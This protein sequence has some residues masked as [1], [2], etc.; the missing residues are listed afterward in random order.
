M[1]LRESSPENE[2][3]ALDILLDEGNEIESANQPMDIEDLLKFL[4]EQSE[5]A[6]GADD[7]LLSRQRIRA[8]Q[9]YHGEKYGNEVEGKSQIISREVL[10]AVEWSMPQ[11]MDAFHGGPTVVAYEP[12]GPED[13]ASAEQET[14]WANYVYLR[15]NNG[16]IQS[17]QA[18]KDALLQKD[19][20]IKVWVETEHQQEFEIYE[21]LIEEEAVLLLMDPDIELV[22]KNE[23]TITLVTPEGPQEVPVMD[24][25]V[26]F[27]NPKKKIR[28][29]ACPPD[30]IKVSRRTRFDHQQSPYF[31]HDKPITKSDLSGV[32]AELGSNENIDDVWSSSAGSST[33]HNLERNARYQHD[34]TG[35]ASS[36]V[37]DEEEERILHEEYVLVDANG[38]GIAE[39]LKIIRMGD[40]ILSREEVSYI[41]FAHLTPNILSHK[42]N[43]L[44]LWDLVNDIQLFKTTLQRNIFDNIYLTNNQRVIA[45]A[46]EVNMDDLKVSRAGGVVRENISGAVRPFPTQPLGNQAFDLLGYLDNVKDERTGI[47][48]LSQGLDP[49][50][51]TSN[52]SS[53]AISQV[54]TASQMRMK[55][56]V[57]VLA[58]GFKQVFW[59]IHVMG[60]EHIDADQVFNLTGNFVTV[61]PSTFKDRKD[62]TV[63]VGLGT[64]QQD[65][66]LSK[67]GLIAQDMQMIA[68]QGGMGRIL[69]ESNVYNL[70]IARAK[71]AGMKDVQMYYSDPA[72]LPPP[73]PQPS[74]AELESQKRTEE[75]QI[76]GQKLQAIHAH[77]LQKL[78]I[79]EQSRV[80]I[81]QMKI[82]ADAEIEADKRAM[83]L[84]QLQEKRYETDAEI[85]IETEQGR[86]AEI[87]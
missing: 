27:S 33:T 72:Q 84:L 53:G 13:V 56:I 22:E 86:G 30:E 55:L 85:K 36:L 41:P 79:T 31:A 21:G 34:D 25:K 48:K 50:A 45:L 54:M 15:E 32:M 5:D 9:D 28:V 40:I 44:S 58:E 23:R 14:Q 17:H 46:G 75:A 47:T 16:F 67:L 26:A 78:Q 87:G 73:E 60:R 38:D 74:E 66:E 59:L 52:V 77:E 49:N 43:G 19:G 83:D 39:R 63:R 70:A 7:S 4:Q 24:I 12:E 65:Q 35:P 2:L 62:L 3:D 69:Q 10:D 8:M 20:I 82:E 61:N 81:A 6:I 29:E 18:I 51:L 42:F 64:T 76:E 71:A 57:R 68:S 11:I 37:A 1:H 80:S